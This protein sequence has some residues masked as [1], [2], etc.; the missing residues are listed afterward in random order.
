MAAPRYAQGVPRNTRTWKK[1]IIINFFYLFTLKNK[2]RNTLKLKIKKWFVRCRHSLAPHWRSLVSRHCLSLSLQASLLQCSLKVFHF[3]NFS[4]F[5][6]PTLSR[7]LS[8]FLFI[9]NHWDE[10]NESLSLSLFFELWLTEQRLKFKPTDRDRSRR[11]LVVG[12]QS[13]LE[14][15]TASKIS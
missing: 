1:Y 4:L 12:D 13:S 14:H 6:S 15:I 5:F 11:S 10:M 2:I 3:T 8:L 9:W 7:S